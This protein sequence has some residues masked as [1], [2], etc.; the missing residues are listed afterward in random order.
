VSFSLRVLFK[1][2]I[3][4]FR[5]DG[6][7]LAGS[8]SYFFVMAIFPFCLFLVSIFGYFL[9]EN[10][11]FYNF[12]L[13][14]LIYFFPEATSEITKELGTIITYRKI[15]LFTLLLYGF[16][17]YQL[18]LSAEKAINVIFKE[19]ATRPFLISTLFS[20]S[21]VTL[22]ITLLIIT[23][24]AISLIPMFKFLTNFLPRLVISKIT[25]ILVGFILP[26][27]LVTVIATSFYI[28]LPKK[29]VKTRHALIGG[30]FTALFLEAAKHLFTFYIALKL[31]NIGTI[32]GSLSAFIIFVLW[33][34]YSASI[35]LIGGEVVHNLGTAK[36]SDHP[37]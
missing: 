2:F 12:F 18:Y 4:F 6:P 15:G 28:F 3:D 29:N 31:S 10:R 33:V 9:G 5:D 1:S 25:I 19:K 17:S 23:F 20:L 13:E 11:E 36:S 21:I 34:F 26:L 27:F 16:F 37:S 32:Y 7:M 24:G 14:K 22:M 8:I 35:F 30:L